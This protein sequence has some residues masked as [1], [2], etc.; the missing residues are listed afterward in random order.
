MP[1]RNLLFISMLGEPSLYKVEDYQSL[2]PSGLEKDWIHDWYGDLAYRY[3]FDME[4]VDVIHG[5]T[6]PD[7]ID[8][9]T[10]ILGGTIHLVLEDK[11]WL[12][13]ILNWLRKYRK[14][15]RPLLGICGGHQMIA[16]NFFQGNQLIPRENGHMFGTF[17]VQ[18]TEAGKR[19]DLFQ[20][21]SDQ[22]EFHFANSYHIVPHHQADL[23]VLATTKDSPAIAVDYGDHW[24]ATQFHPESHKE[25]WAC[26]AKSD[27]RM[28]MSHYK[29]RHDGPQLLENF[30]KLASIQMEKADNHVKT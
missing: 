19:S 6:L 27:T 13:T 8:S 23:T 25:T 11:P 7:P 20:G 1:H 29:T 14:L 4:A 18:L 22:S 3:G 30:I 24:Y 12:K 26:N 16:Y 17:P 15:K 2:C 5:D 28:D 21:M 9:D 10:V